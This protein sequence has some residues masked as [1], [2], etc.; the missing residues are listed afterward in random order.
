[1]C[2]IAGFETGPHDVACVQRLS[3]GLEHRGPD[4]EGW[5]RVGPWTLFQTRLAVV[6][7]SERVRYPMRNE[8]GTLRLLFNGEVYN[9]PELRRDLERRGHRFVTDCDAEVVL[10]GFEEWGTDVLGRL[11]GMF[12]LAIADSVS[13]NLVLARDASGVKPLVYT[14]GPRFAFGSDA[15]VLVAAGLAAGHVNEQE[16]AEYAAFHYVPPP[17]TGL[18]DVV[19]LPRGCFLRRSADG[20]Q[21]IVAWHCPVFSTRP[22]KPTATVD[23]LDEALRVSV[24]RQLAADVSVG[25]FL[26]GGLDSALILDYALEAGARPTALTLGFAGHG[27][28]DETAAA[29]ALCRRA[30]VPHEIEHLDPS[31]SV[32][33]AAITQAYDTPFADPSAIAM[34]QLARLARRHVTVAL[35]GTGGDDLFAGY[36]RHRA[37]M[38]L[39]VARRL[40]SVLLER[41]AA[42]HVSRGGERTTRAAT[43]AAYVRRLAA[44]ARDEPIEAYLELAAG[45]RSPAA[46]DAFTVET[47]PRSARIRVARRHGAVDGATGEAPL[48]DRIQDF[49]LCT[50]LPGDLLVK[51]DRATMACS[52]E[53][54]VP[55]LGKGV[56][57]VARRTAPNQRASLRQGK[58]LLRDVASRRL[59]REHHRRAKRGF[60]VPLRAQFEG[61]WRE[62]AIDR[63]TSRAWDLVDGRRAAAL[64]GRPDVAALDLWALVALTCWEE[65]LEAARATARKAPAVPRQC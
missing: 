16:I 64:V 13:G 48:L 5:Q 59:R 25:V 4:G 20:D 58:R 51:E 46:L 44:V 8:S 10:H 36:R 56:L 3:H 27:D 6:D 28:Y 47:D 24:R 7:L 39:P 52:V 2:G 32:A 45:G 34:V 15:T 43:A 50:Y 1:M 18:R 54:R 57:D 37:H 26:S 19:Q 53:G 41:L 61:P 60:A 23:D 35:S 65:R 62:P 14:T 42:G 31:F 49:E 38:A 30:S 9:H 63:F 33:L 22:S 11:D 17:G 55:F 12:A 40:P 29:A 21:R